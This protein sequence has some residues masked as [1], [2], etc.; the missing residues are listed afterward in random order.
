MSKTEYVILVD[1]N[2]QAI[3]Q[4]E[5]IAAHEKALRHRAFS[6][7]ICREHQGQIEVLLQKRADEKYHCGGLW[8]NTCC[9]HPRPEESIIEAGQRR[10]QE[11]MGISAKLKEVGVFQYI[12]PFDN[13]LTENEIDHVLTGE[14]SNSTITLN[15]EEASDYRWITTTELQNEIAKKPTRF[16]PWLGKALAVLLPSH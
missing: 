2:D 4:E 9:G 14:L 5:K 6:V 10:L 1:E 11:E 15:P 13:G 3:G 8:T 7:F 16:T 12:A